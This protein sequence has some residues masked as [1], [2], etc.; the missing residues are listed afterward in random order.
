[1]ITI[2]LSSVLFN[3]TLL[4]SLFVE[5]GHQVVVSGSVSALKIRCVYQGDEAGQSRI[6]HCHR[7]RVSVTWV[8][9]RKG[10]A[11]GSTFL[12][13]IWNCKLYPL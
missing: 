7:A 4:H 2:A 5:E 13:R 11:K 3:K 8:P 1:M 10:I 6:S 9:C 12:R